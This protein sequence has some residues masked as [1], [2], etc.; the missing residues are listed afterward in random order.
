MDNSTDNGGD[1]PPSEVQSKT[2]LAAMGHSTRV[3]IL[4]AMNSPRRRLSPKGFSA[5][6]GLN[7]RHCSYHFAQLAK[8]RC[9]NLV[10]TRPVRGSTE[11]IYEPNV[12]ALAWTAEWELLSPKIKRAVLTSVYK[13]AI[14]AL[15]S[16]IDG[17]SFESR[18]DSHLSWDT[19][20]VDERGWGEMA[21]IIDPAL[22]ELLKV[23][24]ECLKRIAEGDD[25]F[26][27]T[28][29]MFSFESPRRFTPMPAPS[30][31]TPVPPPPRP[32]KDKSRLR[33]REL[34]EG[35]DEEQIITQAMSHPTRV[36]ILMAMNSPRRRMSA[37]QFARETGLNLD[38]CAYHF[39]ELEDVGCIVLVDSR[40]RRGAKEHIYEPIRTALAW[41]D[42]W[43]ALGP[44]VK[45]SVL[46]K[47]M[48]G[49]V[50]ALGLAINSGTFEARKES[51]LSWNIVEVD[52]QGWTQ[53]AAI[54]DRVLEEMIA[55]EKRCLD[56]IASGCDFINASFFMSSFES[57]KRIEPLDY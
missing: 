6:T 1:S 33:R 48:R 44:I 34:R 24:K 14:E 27:A 4:M 31:K 18:D 52:D 29:F 35:L 8:A 51:H 3:R 43:K 46:A 39:R 26:L 5:E 9:I 38:H 15:G 49:A 30:A 47:V 56:R 12:T 54:F 19:I 25:Y 23:E 42:N 16:A 36:R 22:K 57:P 21:A 40:P 50:E 55:L 11:H 32:T 7:L 53:M 17:G 37:S 10:A 13:A 2:V 20:E 45:Q 41:T 28:Y